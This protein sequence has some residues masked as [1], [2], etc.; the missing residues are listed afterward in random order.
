MHRIVSVTLLVLLGVSALL[1]QQNTGR[2]AGSVVDATGAA[3]PTASVQ[4]SLAGGGV[5]ATSATRTDGLFNFNA[6]QPGTYDLT[7]ESAGF[8]KQIIRGVKVD[9]GREISIPAITMEVTS[10]AEVVEVTATNQ[11]V[12]TTNAEVSTTITTNQIQNLPLLNRSPLALIATQ[13]G[14]T[15]NGRTNTIINGQRPSFSNVTVDGV[16]VQDNFIRTNALD[17]LP[18]M[19]LLD[20]VAGNDGG[21]LEHQRRRRRRLVAGHLHHPVRHQHIPR[22]ACTGSTATGRWPP[23]PGSTT[24][25]ASRSHPITRTR[26]AAPSG[27][28]SSRTSSSSTRTTKPSGWLSNRPTTR[29]SSR[30]TPATASTPIRT[31][32]GRCTRSMCCKPWGCPANSTM[33]AL[34]AKVPGADKINNYRVGDS[35]ESFL[36][37]TAGYSYPLRNDRFRDN[38]TGKVDYIR[39]TKNVFS[40]TFAWNRDYLDRTDLTVNYDPFP[41]CST[42]TR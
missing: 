29:P 5:A 31:P 30:P 26:G 33:A 12:Q 37:N 11:G 25:M 22:N 14:V 18:N 16:N 10:K 24:G 17:F 21:H 1:A 3:I 39:S 32:A 2:I 27:A 34:I 13:A 42:T 38:V 7:F 23:T 40:G 20:Q 28:P 4:L 35:S 6:I 41:R 15:Y 19:L 9:P 8:A 36:R